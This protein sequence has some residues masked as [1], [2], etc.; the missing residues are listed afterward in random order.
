MRRFYRYLIY[1]LYTASLKGKDITPVATVVF[2]MSFVHFAQVMIFYSLVYNFF[3]SVQNYLK[4]TK[5]Q[6]IGFLISF[7][8]LYY[9]IVYDKGRWNKYIDEFKDESLSQRRKGTI[10]V[11]LFT[12]GSI[13]LLF[14]CMITL[15]II[16]W[17]SK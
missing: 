7:A 10:L 6:I 12:I 11:G 13:V 2:I 16:F 3:P 14:V 5:I 17:P 15:S 8:I 4:F 9:L 1:R